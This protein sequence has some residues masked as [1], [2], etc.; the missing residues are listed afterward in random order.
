[1][2]RFVHCSACGCAKINFSILFVLLMDLQWVSAASAI[3]LGSAG[4]CPE[5]LITS[6]Y[7][8]IRE[9]AG[10]LV[11]KA[12]GSRFFPGYKFKGGI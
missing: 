2:T 7:I 12:L 11:E 8:T 10:L 9:S 5:Y 3:R 1:M 6:D 4:Q